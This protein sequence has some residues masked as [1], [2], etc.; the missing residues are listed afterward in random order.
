MRLRRIAGEAVEQ[1]ERI[2]GV[3]VGEMVG[4]GAVLEEFKGDGMGVLFVL[5]ER[6]EE[7]M[8]LRNEVE[9]VMGGSEEDSR[10]A[11]LVGPPGGWSSAE[12]QLLDEAVSERIRPVSM[13]ENVLRTE[14]ACVAAVAVVKSVWD[15]RKGVIEGGK[16]S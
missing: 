7:L 3:E 16:D 2:D 8:S 13:G 1:C 9:S 11:V 4:L 6:R 14:T 15:D 10:V 5:R 12:S